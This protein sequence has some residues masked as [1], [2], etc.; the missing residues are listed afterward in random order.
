MTEHNRQL[1]D[2]VKISR[3]AI[4]I[5]LTVSL[6]LL[7][8][9]TGLVVWGMGITKAQGETAIVLRLMSEELR[10]LKTSLATTSAKRYSIEDATADKQV[11]G[12][13]NRAINDRVDAQGRR[14]DHLELQVDGKPSATMRGY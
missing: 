13:F 7:T 14:I 9:T 6:F 4:G 12:Q 1:N 11:Q 5:G 2:D 3:W 10:E 8:Q